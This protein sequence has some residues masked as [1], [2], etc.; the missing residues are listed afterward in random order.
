M[1]KKKT[2]E[3]NRNSRMATLDQLRETTI[4]AFLSPVPH[5]DT[6]RNWLDKARVP[7]FKT[8][9]HA[10]RG[11]GPVWYSVAAVEKLL[12]SRVLPGPTAALRG[13]SFAA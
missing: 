2:Q 3:L 5:R 12:E 11:G 10:K 7:R 8:N 1:K 13:K 9:P 6:I 4:P